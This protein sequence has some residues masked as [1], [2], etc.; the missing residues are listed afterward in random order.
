MAMVLLFVLTIYFLFRTETV[1][2]EL[3][4]FFLQQGQPD[5]SV[6][7]GAFIFCFQELSICVY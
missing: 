3:N 6:A 2:C 1:R 7:S 4:I 5:D